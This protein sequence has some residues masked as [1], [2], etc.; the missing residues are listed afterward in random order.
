MATPTP[1]ELYYAVQRG[2]QVFQCLGSDLVDKLKVDDIMA[3]HRPRRN[4]TYAW[5]VEEVRLPWE[6]HNG[7]VW[8]VKNATGKM[9]VEWGPYQAYAVDGTDLGS[10]SSI[11]AGQEVVFL[12]DRNHNMQFNV[13]VK[14]TTW[15]FGELNDVSNVTNMRKLLDDC[16]AFNFDISDWDVSNVV[17][18][19]NMFEKC[20]IFN[21]DISGWDTSKVD[22]MSDMFGRTEAFN[23]DIG[24]WD[25][26]N[27]RNMYDMFRFTANF[28]QDIGT[29]Q[30]TV[31]GNTYTAWDTSQVTNM[32]RMFDRA[33]KFNQDLSGWCVS[34]FTSKPTDFDF[35]ADDWVLPRPDWG[36][37]C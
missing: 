11:E 28:N 33:E 36:A 35:W 27:V 21:Q 2:D 26:S 23:Q 14:S 6:K 32:S 5:K 34:Q 13:P 25:T 15:E 37:P 19:S 8:H 12:T 18:M 1:E 10:I 20:T 7:G 16:P 31:N 24:K 3:V 9:W 4:K 29:K 30:V 17:D 22:K